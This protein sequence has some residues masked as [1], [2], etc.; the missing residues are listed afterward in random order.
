MRE[1][2]R[3]R[4]GDEGRQNQREADRERDRRREEECAKESK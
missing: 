3:V 1:R 4:Q 2:G